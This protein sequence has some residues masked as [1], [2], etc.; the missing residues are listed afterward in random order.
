MNYDV[1]QKL[2][3]EVQ[4]EDFYNKYAGLNNWLFYLSWVGNLFCVIFAYFHVDRAI[5]QTL[6][7]PSET[8]VWVVHVVSIALLFALEGLKRI[9]F[10][11]LI[12]TLTEHGMKWAGR[13]LNALAS[14]AFLLVA[15]SFY[16]SLTGAQE[17]ADKKEQVNTE[18]ESTVSV[19]Q[20]SLQAKYDRKIKVYDGRNEVLFA[21]SNELTAKAQNLSPRRRADLLQVI[22]DNREQTVSN[23]VSIQ[24]LKAERDDELQKY[25]THQK[26]KGKSVIA[27]GDNN[28]V[29]F[30]SFSTIAEI[31]ILLGVMF[32][33]YFPYKAKVEYDTISETDPKYLQYE[34]YL[35]LLAIIY[36]NNVRVGDALPT[37]VEMT[38]LLRIAH[39]DLYGK[40]LE[41]ALKIFRHVGVMTRRGN[42]N[43]IKL[44]MDKA[45]RL[46][47]EYLKVG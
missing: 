37:K 38:K 15:A 10:G 36:K 23:D 12:K 30:V 8:T 13:E 4:P 41:D 27:N 44:E 34:Q 47:K 40:Q 2:K 33:G 16:L 25:A 45:Q 42:K 11:K 5:M 20:D 14:L 18:L 35:E 9:L 19:Y 26:E 46:I 39:V 6:N 22:K 29:R 17:Y 43:I 24:K 7:K 1:Y 31:L 28:I 32:R 21:Q 3:K